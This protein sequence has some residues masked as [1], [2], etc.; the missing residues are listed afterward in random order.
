MVDLQVMEVMG[1]HD[2]QGEILATK[3]KRVLGV[4]FRNFNCPESDFG[5]R[6]FV[7]LTSRPWR[8]WEVMTYM[9]KY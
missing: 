1:G 5:L 4:I 8:S 9:V 2:L 7:L 3:Q 6:L